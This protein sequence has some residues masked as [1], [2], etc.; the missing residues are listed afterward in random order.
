[1]T[2]TSAPPNG[3]ESPDELGS[4]EDDEGE[5][6]LPMLTA[7]CEHYVGICVERDRVGAEY[8]KYGKDIYFTVRAGK[9]ARFRPQRLPRARSLPPVATL[10]DPQSPVRP[11]RQRML[12][13]VRHHGR[14]L[15]AYARA[16]AQDADAPHAT[17]RNREAVRFTAVSQE[18]S[19]AWLDIVP[20]G[21]YATTIHSPEF[22]VTL[23]RRGGLAISAAAVAFDSR[24]TAERVDRKG[25]SL[26]NGGEYNRRHNAVLRTVHHMVSAV[27]VGPCVLGDKDDVEKTAALNEGHAVDLAELEGDDTNGGDC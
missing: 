22:T 27:A 5:L 8:D 3:E 23:Q 24:A 1:M 2:A 19:G 16:A 9:I 17:C 18:H 26:A 6:P 14:W 15:D 25:D 20:D 4:S 12:C 11:P 10:F 13:M 21:S 7:F